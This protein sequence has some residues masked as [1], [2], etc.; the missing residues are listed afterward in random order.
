MVAVDETVADWFV[1]VPVSVDDA[2]VVIIIEYAPVSSVMVST[3]LS[4]SESEIE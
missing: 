4:C 1:S 3:E 2:L